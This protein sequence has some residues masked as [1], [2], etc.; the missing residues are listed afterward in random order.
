M[1]RGKYKLKRLRQQRRTTPIQNAGLSERVIR[2]LEAHGVSSL[3]DLDMISDD[4]LN[5]MPRIGET[6]MEEIH[7]AQ[8]HISL[9]KQKERK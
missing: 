2:I 6:A 3:Y 1:A 5:A 4:V 9:T 8:I 7:A